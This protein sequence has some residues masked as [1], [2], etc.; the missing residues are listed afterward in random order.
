MF[1]NQLVNV[2]N[3]EVVED[4]IEEYRAAESP[5][6]VTWGDSPGPG[7]G[8]INNVPDTARSDTLSLSSKDTRSKV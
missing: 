5:D 8:G 4:L 6:Y 2:I 7:L 3:R 1:D